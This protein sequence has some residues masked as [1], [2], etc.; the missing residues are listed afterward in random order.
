MKPYILFDK[1]N[2]YAFVIP[3]NNFKKQNM[4]HDIIISNKYDAKNQHHDAS[5]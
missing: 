3:L 2:A 4:Q 5:A 1:N